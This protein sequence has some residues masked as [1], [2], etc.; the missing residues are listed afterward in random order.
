MAKLSAA[1]ERVLRA[2][3]AGNVIGSCSVYEPRFPSWVEEVPGSRSGVNVASQYHA[4][5][6][7]GLVEKM[8]P[9]LG[10]MKRAALTDAGREEIARLDVQG[11]AYPESAKCAEC[12]KTIRLKRDGTFRRHQ[13]RPV[14]RPSVDGRSDMC[15]GTGR[16]PKT[17]DVKEN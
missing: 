2:I 3:A 14:Q 17:N 12:G 8:R 1:R 10:D 4:L 13:W 16:A 11:P 9:A 5:V 7:L 15:R 6:H